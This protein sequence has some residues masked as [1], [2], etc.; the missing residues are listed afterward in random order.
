MVGTLSDYSSL[1]ERFLARAICR[2]ITAPLSH[3]VQ[4]QN[5]AVEIACLSHAFEIVERA[6]QFVNSGT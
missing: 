5:S 6:V 1:L 2:E 3:P 4:K